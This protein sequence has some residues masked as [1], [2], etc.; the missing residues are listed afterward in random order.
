MMFYTS[1][2]KFSPFDYSA[3]LFMVFNF[4]NIH[5][6]A[7]TSVKIENSIDIFMEARHYNYAS[8]FIQLEDDRICSC[9]QDKTI[10]LYDII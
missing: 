3:N 7:Q 9:S 8:D 1:V 4:V 10:K 5:T 6:F 2:I